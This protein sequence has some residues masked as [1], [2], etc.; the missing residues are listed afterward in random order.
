MEVKGKR[1]CF[2]IT[3]CLCNFEKLIS[4]LKTLKKLGAEI[5]PIIDD[6]ALDIEKDIE[7]ICENKLLHS[8]EDVKSI[9]HKDLFDVILVAPASENTISKLACNIIDTP[10]L[11][12]V[13]FHVRNN[14][15]V[16]IAPSSI[17][18]LRS[19]FD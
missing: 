14:L 7:E 8:L 2:I 19:K 10:A 13:K 18:G 15:P 1:I 4:E 3:D 12:A 16:V 17:D 6:F 9:S 5:L 11:E